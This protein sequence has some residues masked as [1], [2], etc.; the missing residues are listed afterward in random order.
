MRGSPGLGEGLGYRCLC[1]VASLSHE[2]LYVCAP[3]CALPCA[4]G[5]AAS[6]ATTA[7]RRRG[8]R[9]NHRPIGSR[10]RHPMLRLGHPENV[11][12]SAGSDAGGSGL[13]RAGVSIE[14]GRPARVTRLTSPPL[15]VASGTPLPRWNKP[16][17]TC[18]PQYNSGTAG[19]SPLNGR[20]PP[21][22]RCVLF[23]HYTLLHDCKTSK[24]QAASSKQQAASS[25]QQA[26][27]SKQQ[28][29]P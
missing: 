10:P 13:P 18:P 8:A 1:V 17:F 2:G 3:P 24:Q 16:P 12:V 19:L 6:A 27:S 7:S 20:Y 23:H 9:G 14:V 22:P 29:A 26:A 25:K 5:R 4:G 28:A 11:A 21:H 15:A